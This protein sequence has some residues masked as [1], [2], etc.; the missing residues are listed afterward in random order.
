MQHHDGVGVVR[1]E[2]LHHAGEIQ[3][4][5]GSIVVGI[6]DHGETGCLEQGAVVFPARVA[7]GD[8][9]IRVQALEEV[10]AD[11][12]RAGA[13]KCLGGHNPAFGDQRRF[14]AE[15]QGLHGL[16]VGGD[17]FDRQVATRGGGG[18]AS[19]FGFLH[20]AQQ[21]DFPFVGEVHANTQIDLGGTGIGIEGFIQAQDRVAWGHLDGR[22]Q[23][24]L[25]SRG[26]LCNK[27][28]RRRMLRTAL[29]SAGGPH[30]DTWPPTPRF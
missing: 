25:G 4:V 5:A 12:Q 29:G 11:L 23:T 14:L 7:D 21:R 26:Q 15:Q 17:A 19:L 27:T 20:G 9:G 13:A 3:A 2:R 10:G 22:K 28:G 1:L 6:V 30:L 18:Q 8:L 24:H 16:V